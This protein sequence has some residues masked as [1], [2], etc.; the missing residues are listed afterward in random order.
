MTTPQVKAALQGAA[1][2]NS[3]PNNS[4]DPTRSFKKKRRLRVA[5]IHFQESD[6]ELAERI[7]EVISVPHR[8]SI[9]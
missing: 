3:T 1:L 6:E 7:T 2:K 8:S 4:V 5:K 9:H